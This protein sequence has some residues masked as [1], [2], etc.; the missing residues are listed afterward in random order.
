MIWWDKKFLALLESANFSARFYKRFVDDGNIKLKA[1]NSGAQ[2]DSSTMQ[3]VYRDA[4][5]ERQPDKRTADV[6]KEISDSVTEMLKKGLKRSILS[7]RNQWQIQYQ[8]LQSLLFQI[9]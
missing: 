1:L 3:V 9:Q 4:I 2:W 7:T 8:F 6:V 5:D